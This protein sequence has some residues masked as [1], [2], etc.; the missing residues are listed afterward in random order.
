MCL[1]N[2]NAAGIRDDET[3]HKMQK[4]NPPPAPVMAADD[5]RGRHLKGGKQRSGA[6]PLVIVAE[7]AHGFAVGQSQPALGALERL[8]VGLF[9]NRQH[10]RI[11]RRL[12]VEP[13][14][15]GGLLRKARIGA[16]TPAA[17]PRQ[18]DL[19]AA[20]HPPDLMLGNVAQMPR[21]Q[22]AIPARVTRW[23]RLIQRRQDATL[24]RR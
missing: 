10:R 6:M 13:D 14:H 16:H 12:Q 11:V 9:V 19:M 3:V 24:V 8:D 1:V 22:H 21:Q 4:F 23:R 2:W 7:P 20:Q 17:A 18:A 15:I 5:E